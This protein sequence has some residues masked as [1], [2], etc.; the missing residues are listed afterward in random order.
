MKEGEMG[1]AVVRTTGDFRADW[2]VA[3]GILARVA[4]LPPSAK[5]DPWIKSTLDEELGEIRFPCG[6]LKAKLGG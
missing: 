6:G 3:Y 2:T 1:G 4:S 5:V